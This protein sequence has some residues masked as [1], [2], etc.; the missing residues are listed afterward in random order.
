MKFA[1]RDD[2][3]NFFYSPEDIQRNYKNIWD[4]CPVSMATVPFIKGNWPKLVKENEL[5]GPGVMNP[6]LI[7]SITNDNEIHP[8]DANNE[9]VDFIKGK[10]IEK[11]IYLTI[12]GIHHRN[13]DPEIPQLTTNFGIGAEFY[14]IRNLTKPLQEAI[15]YLEK[16]FGQPIEI[17][18]FPQEIYTLAGLNAVLANNLAICGHFPSVRSFNTL[19]MFGIRNYLHYFHFKLFDRKISRYPYTIKNDRIK[20]VEAYS[21]NNQLQSIFDE[22]DYVHKKDGV[23]VLTTHSYAFDWEHSNNPGLTVKEVIQQVIDYAGNK[24]NLQFV[25]LKQIFE[26][27]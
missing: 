9:L 2:D 26:D 20:I 11:K 15:L 12:H 1:L 8:L 23:F 16:L 4:I 24:K 14:T 27:Q 3:L 21:S 10:I 18:A 22:I 25:N 5:R 7:E 19:R 13:E 6:E 17:I